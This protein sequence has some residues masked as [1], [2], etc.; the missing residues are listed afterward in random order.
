MSFNTALFLGRLTLL[1]KEIKDSVSDAKDLAKEH[2]EEST[3]E[4]AKDGTISMKGKLD[5]IDDACERFFDLVNSLVLTSV[6]E[7]GGVFAVEALKAFEGIIIKEVDDLTD[8]A[9]LA[10]ED[11]AT[12]VANQVKELRAEAAK[13][14][15][16]K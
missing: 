7:K 8:R 15:D 10:I 9:E 3:Q 4:A 16:L 6:E 12:F 13:W 2:T 1:A 14:F 5:C 11:K